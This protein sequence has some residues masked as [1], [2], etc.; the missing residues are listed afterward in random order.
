[1]PKFPKDFRWV[2]TGKTLGQGGQ[3]QVYLVTDITGEHQGEYALKALSKNKPKQAYERF[4]RELE[5]INQLDHKYIIKTVDASSLSEKFQYYVM[6]YVPGAIS[7]ERVLGTPDNPYYASPEKAVNLFIM[8]AQALSA[9]GDCDPR[10][11]HRDLSPSNI[12][13][14]PDGSI[15]IIDFGLCQIEGGHPI[16]LVDE[17][18]G[19][20][21]Y[22]S[23][24]CETGG[25]GLADINSDLYSAGKILWSAITNRRAFSREKTAFTT[26]AMTKI[27]PHNPMTWHLFHIFSKTIR[28]NYQDRWQNAYDAIMGA[29]DVLGLIENKYQPLEIIYNKCPICGVG[30][31]D[32]FNGNHQ[33]FGNPNP[34]GIYGE[35]CNYC[36]Y[37]MAIDYDLYKKKLEEMEN[38]E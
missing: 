8:I 3:A 34:P 7:L 32:Q 1:M 14:I 2:Q 18:V 9:C 12:L 27:F 36:G 17:G 16:T 10:V 31:L 29:W 21:N 25:S 20:L 38:L 35:R 28:F 26:N 24:E 11:V 19:T 13:L 37:C 30:K 22:M 6:E 5:A 23:P 33:V 15:R 4:H